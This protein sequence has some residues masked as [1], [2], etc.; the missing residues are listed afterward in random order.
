MVVAVA[1]VVTMIKSHDTDE[2]HE[3]T[4][5]TDDEELAKTVHLAPGRK[6][7][8][9]LVDDFNTDD[10]GRSQRYILDAMRVNSHEKNAIGKP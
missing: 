3:K 9:R 10:P 4:S 7:L 5:N 2:I 1:V 6:S 8:H